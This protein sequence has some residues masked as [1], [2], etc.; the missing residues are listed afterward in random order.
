M[1]K[2]I[3]ASILFLTACSSDGENATE[4]H[5]TGDASYRDATTDHAGAAREPTAPTQ[6][7]KV[8][9]IVK[10]TGTLPQVDARCALDPAGQFEAR[11]A[12]TVDFSDGSAYLAAIGTAAITT[13]SGCELPTLSG[14]IVTDVRIRAEIEATTQSC[15]TY[16]QA[17]A[18]AEAEQSC[19][20]TAS[21]ASCRGTAEATAEG[22]CTTTCTTSAEHIVAETSLAA[23]LFGDLDAEDLRA[24]ALGDLDA[25]LTFDHLA[26]ANGER[27]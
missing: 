22:T 1:L 25:N 19:G 24:A 13:P 7:A 8:T 18:R 27:L 5:V 12:S 11:Y 4:S 20:A 6:S 26:D 2:P 14:A 23:A 15:E 17:Y 21:A 10:G 9:V 3:L 16:C